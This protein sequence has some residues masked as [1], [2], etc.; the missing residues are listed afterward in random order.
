MP[1]KVIGL[2]SVKPLLKFYEHGPSCEV[3]YPAAHQLFPTS[4]SLPYDAELG[5]NQAGV[6]SPCPGPF[7]EENSHW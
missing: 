5:K 1:A 4:S 6:Q 3:D 2:G 7:P